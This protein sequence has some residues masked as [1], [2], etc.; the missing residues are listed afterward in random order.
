MSAA[1]MVM[2]AVEVVAAEVG[3]DQQTLQEVTVM[4]H[5]I[6]NI[7]QKTQLHVS[8]KTKAST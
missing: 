7:L 2:I 3:R 4:H 8:E 5:E 6:F 1:V